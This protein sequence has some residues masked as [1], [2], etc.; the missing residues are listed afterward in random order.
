MDSKIDDTGI[1]SLSLTD[2]ISDDEVAMLYNDSIRF[3]ILSVS[4][5][6]DPEIL[7]NILDK[8]IA[9]SN[10]EMV[11]E[12]KTSNDDRYKIFEGINAAMDEYTLP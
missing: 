4:W 1:S 3:T 10:I 8:N 2:K 9:Q 5:V 12:S 11:V 7:G 6:L